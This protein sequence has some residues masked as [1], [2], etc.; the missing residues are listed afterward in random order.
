MTAALSAGIPPWRIIADPGIGFAKT[1]AQNAQLLR[2]LPRFVSHFGDGIGVRAA[3]CLVG[4]SRK[5]FI[6][7]LLA[8]PD[9]LK[10]QWGNAATV[11]A[12]VAG[13]ADFVRVHEVNEMRQVALVSDA[14][15]RD[16]TVP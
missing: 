8:Q 14:I 4:A 12:S 3:A 7:K 13:G 11:C 15:H 6:G 10:R 16:R 1:H 5:G 2:E 9:P